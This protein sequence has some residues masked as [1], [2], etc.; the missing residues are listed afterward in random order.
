MALGARRRERVA[1]PRSADAWPRRRRGRAR[2]PHA[3][4]G[5][6]GRAAPRRHPPHVPHVARAGAHARRPVPVHWTRRPA[7]LDP[8]SQG[9]R[10][11]AKPPRLPGLFRLPPRSRARLSMEPAPRVQASLVE[12]LRDS[13]GRRERSLLSHRRAVVVASEHRALR[14]SV[15]AVRLAHRG[16]VRRRARRGV[17][18]RALVHRLLDARER[19]TAL[20]APGRDRA[21]LELA[22]LRLDLL[23]RGLSQQPPRLSRFGAHGDRALRVRPRLACRARGRAPR[24]DS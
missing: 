20:R 5:A 8:A 9:A 22:S 17:D 23:W 13:G 19:R 10:L 15:D 1:S 12:A 24:L 2:L 3:L 16:G 11:L 7:E 18:P 21:R 4:L 14:G 6:F